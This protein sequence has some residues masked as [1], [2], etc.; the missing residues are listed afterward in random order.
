[1]AERIECLIGYKAGDEVKMAISIFNGYPSYTGKILLEN[2][3]EL[4]K[5]KEL[6]KEKNIVFLRESIKNTEFFKEIGYFTFVADF[7]NDARKMQK[8]SVAG[9]LVKYVYVFKD[10]K[11]FFG[12]TDSN[13]FL[14]ELTQESCA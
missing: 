7:Y 6:V 11:W 3:N 8:Q 1:M 5:V 9:D 12:D 2:Y 13:V 10:N 4:A 14:K